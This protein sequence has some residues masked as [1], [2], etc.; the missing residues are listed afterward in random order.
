MEVQGN[1]VTPGGGD[2]EQNLS[3]ANR[4][5]R[6]SVSTWLQNLGVIGP[7]CPGPSVSRILSK[8]REECMQDDICYRLSQSS[9]F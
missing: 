5:L 9:L 8:A 1:K 3:S 4:P 6:R 2:G 7:R